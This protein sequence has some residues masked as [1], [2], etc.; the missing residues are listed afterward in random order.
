MRHLYTIPDRDFIEE[1]TK[2]VPWHMHRN[3]SPYAIVGE[4][5]LS[6]ETCD[7]I[8][9]SML[10]TTPYKFDHCDASTREAHRPLARC[11]A[12]VLEFTNQANNSCW[13][14]DLDWTSPAAWLQSYVTGDSYQTHQDA[15]LGQTR[16]L[17]TIVMLS[18][19]SKYDGGELRIIPYPTARIIPPTRGTMVTFPG[20]MFHEVLPVRRGHRQTLN[21]GVWGPAWR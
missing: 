7:E 21:L 16:K 9:L 3:K 11:F 17:T 12:P 4:G 20:W 18:N 10:D 2:V 14:F 19:S 5:V 6:D 13:N 15:V 1:T 8:L